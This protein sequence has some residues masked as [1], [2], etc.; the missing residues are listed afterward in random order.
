MPTKSRTTKKSTG[1][2][3]KT[4][5][6]LEVEAK[7]FLDSK[8]KEAVNYPPGTKLDPSV[9]HQVAAIILSG[10]LSSGGHPREEELLEE[11]F[12]LADLVLSKQ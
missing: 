1:T 9:R 2:N 3:K 5:T 7:Q 10:L 12:R 11:A 8:K 4:S 6:Q